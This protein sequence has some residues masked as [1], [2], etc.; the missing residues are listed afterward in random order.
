MDQ[1]SHALHAAAADPP[2]TAIDLDQL[3]AGERRRTHNRY[4]FGAAT[5]AAVLVAGAVA[6]P[7]ALGGGSGHIAGTPPGCRTVYYEPGTVF[8]P[9]PE[10]TPSTPPVNHGTSAPHSALPIDHSTSAPHSP[11]PGVSTAAV[12]PQEPIGP[13]P[14][15]GTP[16]TD[17]DVLEELLDAALTDAVHRWLPDADMVNASVYDR[18]GL[19]HLDVDRSYLAYVQLGEAVLQVQVG[20]SD[21]YTRGLCAYPWQS[22][23]CEERLVPGAKLVKGGLPGK[24]GTTIEAVTAAKQDGTEVRLMLYP[25]IQNYYPGP[26][27]PLPL[28]VDQLTAIAMDPGLTLFP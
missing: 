24:Y 2:P 3:I 10:S 25:D 9:T 4:R 13:S 16:P 1:L 5:G 17:C 18:P 23:S 19:F 28:T 7:F 21:A 26:Y 6:V 8:P 11:S 22:P 27:A 12:Q 20:A 15:F 14:T